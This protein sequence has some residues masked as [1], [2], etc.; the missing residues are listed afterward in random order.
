MPNMPPLRIGQTYRIGGPVGIVT[1]A[2]IGRI[3]QRDLDSRRPG[4]QIVSG[5][6]FRRRDGVT[7]V[8]RSWDGLTLE[9]LP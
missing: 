4:R 7:Y 5:P 2:Y 1:A 8:I 3:V 9:V 6:A